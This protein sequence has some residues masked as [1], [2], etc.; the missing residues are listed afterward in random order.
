M[1]NRQKRQNKFLKYLLEFFRI[2]T[3]EM[4]KIKKK[5]NEFFFACFAV[6]P[7]TTSCSENIENFI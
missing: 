7:I 1:K 4:S 5:Q 6:L 2:W 3:F